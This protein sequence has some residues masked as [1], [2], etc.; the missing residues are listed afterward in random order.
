M[1]SYTKIGLSYV[2]VLKHGRILTAHGQASHDMAKLF[3]IMPKYGIP[4]YAKDWDKIY[5][6]ALI[7][8]VNFQKDILFCS[9]IYVFIL[10]NYSNTVIRFP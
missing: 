1:P 7:V 2:C 8:K 5:Q 4:R 9:Q 3:S 10:D 6:M